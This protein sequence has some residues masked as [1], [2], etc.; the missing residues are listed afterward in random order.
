[1][2]SVTYSTDPPPRES[3]APRPREEPSNPSFPRATSQL[4]SRRLTV[5]PPVGTPRLVH[6]EAFDRVDLLGAH[7]TVGAALKQHRIRGVIGIDRDHIEIKHAPVPALGPGR[8]NPLERG[9]G[10]FIAQ[11]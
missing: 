3:P 2:R 6:D 7:G 8:E 11:R 5:T 4:H 1:M 9:K 10:E